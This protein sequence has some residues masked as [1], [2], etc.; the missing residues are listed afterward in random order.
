MSVQRRKTA[1]RNE[2]NEAY[3]SDGSLNKDDSL[4]EEWKFREGCTYK[5]DSNPEKDDSLKL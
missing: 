4:K 1:F 3:G 5:N 2:K